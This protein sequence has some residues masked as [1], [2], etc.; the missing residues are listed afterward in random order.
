[1]KYTTT[2]LLGAVKEWLREVEYRVNKKI[3]P[4]LCPR[5]Y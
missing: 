5:R 2:L 1:M 4:W 3:G